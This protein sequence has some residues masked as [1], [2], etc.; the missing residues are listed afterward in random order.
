M[1][2]GF[3]EAHQSDH[4]AD[5]VCLGS[6]I[7][8]LGA[9]ITAWDLVASAIVLERAEQV[10]GVTALSLGECWVPGNV[11][12]QRWVEDSPRAAFVISSALPWV[13]TTTS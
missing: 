7:G 13:I 3:A 11:W 4:A 8:G 1:H 6:G 10:G 2:P 9:A 5:V 12:K